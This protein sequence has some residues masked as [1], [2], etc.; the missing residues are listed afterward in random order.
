[1]LRTELNPFSGSR[2]GEMPQ[3]MGSR[4]SKITSFAEIRL[5]SYNGLTTAHIGIVFLLPTPRAGKA[6][7]LLAN[8]P[9]VLPINGSPVSLDVYCLNRR[10]HLCHPRKSFIGLV[11]CE[12]TQ[13]AHVLHHGCLDGRPSKRARA[14]SWFV[15]DLAH[16]R[17]A[18]GRRF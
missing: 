18:R 16:E 5:V 17:C 9:A 14:H 4:C 13:L 2:D 15:V 1:M 10:S 3:R 11:R 7:R 6:H 12:H 8:C